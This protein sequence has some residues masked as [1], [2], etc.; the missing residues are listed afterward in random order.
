M[1]SSRANI[2]TG[3]R[4]DLLPCFAVDGINFGEDCPERLAAHVDMPV[5]ESIRRALLPIQKIKRKSG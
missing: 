1:E 3:L 5:P 4:I 2:N